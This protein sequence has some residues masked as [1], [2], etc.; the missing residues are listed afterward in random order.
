MRASVPSFV[1]NK[2]IPVDLVGKEWL[3]LLWKYIANARE[4]ITSTLDQFHATG[5]PYLPTKSNTIYS[6]V[7]SAEAVV[8]DIDSIPALQTKE[9]KACFGEL[10]IPLFDS[11]IITIN[12]SHLSSYLLPPTAEGLLLAIGNAASPLRCEFQLFL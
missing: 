7:E 4:T 1:P 9:W 12:P 2:P 11:S 10:K 5:I 3:T 8:F 6:S